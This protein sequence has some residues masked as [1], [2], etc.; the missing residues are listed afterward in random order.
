M[1]ISVT[2]F[3]LRP[4]HSHSKEASLVSTAFAY[5][6]ASWGIVMALSPILQ[7]RTIRISQSSRG[8]SVGYLAVLFVGFI[9]WLSYGVSISNLAL[10]IPNIVSA[11]V[12]GMTIVVVRRYRN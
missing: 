12:C 11:I 3:W 8:V 4:D 6:A 9:L 2:E 7:I 10:I 1:A 5:T